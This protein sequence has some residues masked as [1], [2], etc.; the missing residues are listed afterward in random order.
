MT[1]QKERVFEQKLS[2]LF[3]GEMSVTAVSCRVCILVYMY[4]FCSKYPN[5]RTYKGMCLS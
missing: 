5:Y 3:E 2:K 1:K 4:E